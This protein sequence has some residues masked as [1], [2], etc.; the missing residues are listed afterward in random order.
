MAALVDVVEVRTQ[1]APPIVVDTSAA[2][3]STSGLG[4]LGDYI[5]PRI[6]LSSRS[7]GTLLDYAPQ[8]EPDPGRWQLTLA[9]VAAVLFLAAYGAWKL[10]K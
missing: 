2:E 3:G 4:W 6:I 9:A 10:L 1:V 5:K 7:M 8:G